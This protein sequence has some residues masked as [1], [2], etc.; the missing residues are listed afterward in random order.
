MGSLW[1][2]LQELSFS[3]YELYD[4]LSAVLE[5]YMN[6]CELFDKKAR[7]SVKVMC[8]NVISTFWSFASTEESVLLTATVIVL[9]AGYF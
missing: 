6:F 5:H 8:T 3:A 2:N 4:K 1:K 7:A 9:L